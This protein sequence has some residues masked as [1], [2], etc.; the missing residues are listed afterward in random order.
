MLSFLKIIYV[1]YDIQII[2]FE[3]TFIRILISIHKVKN[4][5]NYRFGDFLSYYVRNAA[6]K[7][8]T[9]AI[10]NSRELIKL[11]DYFV[12]QK[13]IF[14]LDQT[15]A[16]D[17]KAFSFS[18]IST[19]SSLTHQ[20]SYNTT[21]LD[22]SRPMISDTSQSISSSS[23]ISSGLGSYGIIHDDTAETSYLG[24]NVLINA[25][26]SKNIEI[27][28]QVSAKINTIIHSKSV[29]GVEEACYIIASVD[30]VV[31]NCILTNDDQHYAF[32][33]PILKSLIEKSHTLLQM[34]VHVP[35]IPCSNI[36]PTFYEDFKD[37]CISDEWRHFVDNQVVPLKEQYMAMTVIP[38]QMN[39]EIVWNSCYESSMVSIHKR[40]R[41]LGESKIKF[42]DTIFNRW[43]QRKADENLR[44]N[45]F[46]LELKRNNL[47]MR[48][49][50]HIELKYLTS[51]IGAW[52]EGARQDYWML[53]NHENR[54]RMRCKLVENL[55]F[56]SHLEASRL[57]DYSRSDHSMCTV[58]ASKSQSEPKD[59][60][61]QNIP[62][63]KEAI[64]SQINEDVVA[65]EE[66]NLEGR[67]VQAQDG[68][69]ATRRSS[70]SSMPTVSS[71][72][73]PVVAQEHYNEY[74]QLEE[75]E[76]IIIRCEC[77]LITVTKVIKGRFELTN[78]YIY[79]FDTFSPFYYLEEMN[80]YDFSYYEYLN[81]NQNNNSLS[82]Y[83]CH[84]FN[85]LNDVKLPLVQLKEVQLRRYNLRRSALEF[86]LIN[87]SSYLINFNKTYSDYSHILHGEFL[88][89]YNA[90]L[91]S[92]FLV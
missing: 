37:Y 57:R 87:E 90:D 84:D 54:L 6:A 3:F 51:E 60:L 29:L 18:T 49:Q 83:S 62:I 78:K 43:K 4:G 61:S 35:N 41:L 26:S 27:C 16:F 46:L 65:D 34:I 47:S 66:F 70:V 82:G 7:E 9:T 69:G 85:I 45:N 32:L 75:K 58:V 44:Y 86:F 21:S 73:K 20:S 81:A 55:N 33:I 59:K 13:T 2:M 15:N 11:I 64:N 63:S 14:I 71:Q 24:M 12:L 31:H 19:F 68:S 50:L 76:K 1:I 30:K 80:G 52:N 89:I 67:N 23:A 53:S 77:E 42:E 17:S 25:L 74:P 22:E 56:D 48:K 36:C 10:E 92:G 88:I 91:T 79:F 8:H 39:M 40:N 28:A 72:S 5:L 38:C